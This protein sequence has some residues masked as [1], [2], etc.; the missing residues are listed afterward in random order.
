MNVMLDC[1]AMS[2]PLQHVLTMMGPMMGL[3]IGFMIFLAEP[4]GADRLISGC[5]AQPPPRSLVEASH[6]ANNLSSFDVRRAHARSKRPSALL[7]SDG[8]LKTAFA[9]GLLVGWSETGTRP[10][11][12][13][14]TA[15]GPGALIAVFAFLGQP[16]D[17]FIADLFACPAANWKVMAQR[18][19]AMVDASLL[20]S[21]AERHRAGARLL[22]AVDGN[23]ARRSGY[24]DIGW[25]ALHRRAKARQI[26]ASIFHSAVNL[27]LFPQT[28]S[29]PAEAGGVLPRNY[30]FRHMGSGRPILPPTGRLK[31][32]RSIYV[33]HNDVVRRDDQ[34]EF[35]TKARRRLVRRP[36]RGKLSLRTLLY[37]ND[38]ARAAVLPLHVVTIKRRRWSHPVKNFDP[39]YMRTIFERSYRAARMGLLWGN[40][41][42]L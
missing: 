31:N 38:R 4:A 19:A 25:I 12:D 33:M 5:W 36:P 30:A 37:L 18:A 13:V 23:A 22:V 20:S 10:E 35:K 34:S 16:G 14:V 28:G 11:F 15:V 42:A 41:G 6:V 21:I 8:S 40:L 39:I 2:R 24:W 1:R 27:S 17:R 32:Y 26:I 7:L 9:A 29:L 3:I